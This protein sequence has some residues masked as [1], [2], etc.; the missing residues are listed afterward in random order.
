MEDS[1][2]TYEYK[3]QDA[4]GWRIFIEAMAGPTLVG[5]LSFSLLRSFSRSRPKFSPSAPAMKADGL[6]RKA[7][8]RWAQA[9][10]LRG[11]MVSVADLRGGE[12]ALS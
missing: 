2:G 5:S 12:E 3:V 8:R 11:P 4:L 9:S 7:P 6:A 10:R 1:G